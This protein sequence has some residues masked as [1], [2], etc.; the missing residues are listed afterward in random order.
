MRLLLPG[1]RCA[2]GAG[3]WPPLNVLVVGAGQDPLLA[4]LVPRQVSGDPAVGEDQGAVADP[5]QLRKVGGD[6]EDSLARGRQP[7]EELVD[8]EARADVDPAGRLIADEKLGRR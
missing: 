1:A 8:L 5:H 4:E 7:P 6:D 2:G 3:S